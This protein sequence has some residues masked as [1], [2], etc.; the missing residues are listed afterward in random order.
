MTFLAGGSVG[1][2]VRTHH[3][4]HLIAG[5]DFAVRLQPNKTPGVFLR[6]TGGGKSSQASLYA[7]A[8]C[9]HDV[10][11]GGLIYGTADL[12]GNRLEAEAALML[13]VPL[14]LG[15]LKD[16][17]GYWPA[18]GIG[19][20][21]GLALTVIL[22]LPVIPVKRR[23]VARDAE[24]GVFECSHREKG[25]AL[26]SRWAQGYAKAEPGRLLFQ[27]KTG[28][29]GPLTGPIEIYSSPAPVGEPMKAPWFAFPRGMV[30]TLETDK[31]TVEIAASPASLDMLVN[32]CSGRDS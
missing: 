21:L 8:L 12:V 23:R 29:T 15:P 27:F 30:L 3:Q 22:S 14:I 9:L 1:G 6:R 32:R 19:V 2:H 10:Y 11:Q 5:A 20:A 18:V 28:L 13:V 31:G 17:F 25:S 24:Q 16:A 7:A 4:A 26:K